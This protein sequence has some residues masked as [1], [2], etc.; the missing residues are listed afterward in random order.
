MKRFLPASRTTLVEFVPTKAGTFEFMRHGHAARPDHRD[1]AG[2][3][4]AMSLQTSQGERTATIPV[5]G[6]TC[7][8]CTAHVAKALKATPR[9]VQ[10]HLL[11]ETACASTPSSGEARGACRRGARHGYRSEL[12]EAAEIDDAEG[13]RH[14]RCGVSRP[15]RQGPRQPGRRPL[16][17]LLSM[18]V[19][20][21]IAASAHHA[22][23]ADPLMQWS[24]T[25]LDSWLSVALP[26]LYATDARVPQW[27]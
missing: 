15:R 24:H 10:R 4:L 23:A 3:P 2:R 13:A 7:A 26:W 1:L 27:G 8:S 5:S 20:S 9:R 14:R 16:G 25:W 11:L 18:P 17:M 6:M 21:A 22:T 12:S 19:M